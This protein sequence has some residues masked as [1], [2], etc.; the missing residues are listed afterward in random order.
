VDSLSEFIG[1]QSNNYAEYAGLLA[2]LDWALRKQNAGWKFDLLIRTDS[3]LMARQVNGIYRC[4][5]ENLRPLYLE[6]LS[7]IQ[8]LGNKVTVEHVRRAENTAADALVNITLDS[9]ERWDRH[10]TQA[11]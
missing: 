1:V 4:K 5:N 8:K 3:E 9:I 2:A 6:A 10:T 7:K 11:A